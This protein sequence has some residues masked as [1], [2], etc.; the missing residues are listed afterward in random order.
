MESKGI[1]KYALPGSGFTYTQK[2]I[3]YACESSFVVTHW[4]LFENIA[5]NHK[6]PLLA[7][8]YD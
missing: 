6:N 5:K 1:G 8:F 7:Y 2:Y 4:N 3:Q